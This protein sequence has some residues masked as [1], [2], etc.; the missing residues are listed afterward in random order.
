MQRGLYNTRNSTWCY[1]KGIFCEMLHFKLK[2]I[3]SS[4]SCSSGDE[5]SLN[6]I[7]L[8]L[9]TFF[10]KING[11]SSFTNCDNSNYFFPTQ[12][13]NLS[14]LFSYVLKD[15]KAHLWAHSHWWCC[16]RLYSMS[17]TKF[18]SAYQ[19]CFNFQLA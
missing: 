15:L 10:I 5:K 2:K 19:I 6:G 12:T 3:F 9:K 1:M 17:W 16:K 7:Y 18:E 13:L 14:M 4:C 11:V 8:I